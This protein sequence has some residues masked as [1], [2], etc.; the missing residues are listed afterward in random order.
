M[1]TFKSIFASIA[2]KEP[3]TVKPEK[4]KKPTKDKSTKGKKEKVEPKKRGRPT[5]AE[6]A[7]KA[8]EKRDAEIAVRKQLIERQKAAT[9]SGSLATPAE[10]NEDDE[11]VIPEYKTD[12]STKVKDPNWVPPWPVFLPGQRVEYVV[13]QKDGKPYKGTVGIDDIHSAFIRVAWDDGSCQFHAKQALKLIEKK[14]YKSL[15]KN[16]KNQE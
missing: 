8:K 1:K 9:V 7:A 15:L 12:F 6:L 5:N 14:T 4:T 2:S 11:R 16:K 13:K 10:Y 3:K